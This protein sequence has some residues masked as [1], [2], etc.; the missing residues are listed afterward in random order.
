MNPSR[1]RFL[2][3]VLLV[4]LAAIMGIV[5]GHFVWSDSSSVKLS[6]TSSR[7]FNPYRSEQRRSTPGGSGEEGVPGGGLFGPGGGNEGG[8]GSE[9]S[10]GEGEGRGSEGGSSAEGGS[11]SGVSSS[12]TSKV[13]PALVDINTQLGLESGAAAGTGMVVSS[14][15]V[16]IT[17]NHVITGATKITATD[18]GNGTTYTAKVVGYDHGHDI[19]VLQLEGASGLKTVSFGD[20]SSLKTDEN[21]ATIGN[22]GGAGGTPTAAAGQIT[23]LNQSITAGDEVDGGSERLTGLIQLSG[24]LQPGDSGGPLVNESGEVIGMDT[25]ASTTFQIQ[26]SADQGFAIPIAEVQSIAG[27]IREGE[28]SGTIHIGAT[29][30]LGVFLQSGNGEEGATIENVI[31]DTPAATSG[32]TAGDTITAL[33]GKSVSSPTDLTELML[34]KHPGEKVTLTYQ[35]QAGAQETATVTLASGPP[36]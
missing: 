32:L 34:A 2:D 22:A 24:D 13:D 16:V 33:D 21:V 28:A 11:S 26:S 14:N 7:A 10:G 6:P 3:G 1:K 23:G 25:A 31:S 27:Q 19:A 4:A 35:T 20:S 15:G 12:V 8:S 36:S 18:I 29:G 9:G 17:N 30:L 5:V